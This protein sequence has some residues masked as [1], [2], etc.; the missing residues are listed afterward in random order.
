MCKKAFLCK[1]AITIFKIK[2]F[3]FTNLKLVSSERGNK[4]DT[5]PIVTNMYI[6]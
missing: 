6:Q 3:F 4:N 1:R 5:N 2:G